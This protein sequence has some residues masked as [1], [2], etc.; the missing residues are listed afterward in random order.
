MG[1]Q[2]ANKPEGCPILAAFFA[3]KACPELAEGVGI[4]TLSVGRTLLSAKSQQHNAPNAT[5][6]GEDFDFPASVLQCS[7]SVRTGQCPFP[8][9]SEPAK[10]IPCHS[11]PGKAYSLV[12]PNRA[13]PIPLSFRTGE[14]GEEP[15]VSFLCHSEPAPF[16][17][18]EPAVVPPEAPPDTK[19]PPDHPGRKGLPQP[20]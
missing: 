1:N 6:T 15:A 14:A 19:T 11:D 8:C 18:E 3:A 7:L 10:P 4:L 16:A 2:C 13:R 20:N 5:V 17:G 9:H 12:I